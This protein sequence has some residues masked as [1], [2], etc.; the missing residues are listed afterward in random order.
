M[1]FPKSIAI[2]AIHPSTKTLYSFKNSKYDPSAPAHYHVAISV[3]D[4]TFVLL[5]MIT[6]QGEKRKDYYKHN[7]KALQS[8]IDID[9]TDISILTKKSVIDCNQPLYYTREELDLLVDGDIENLEATISEEIITKIKIA[10]QNSPL[11]KPV[12]KK[13]IV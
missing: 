13:V 1:Q 8:V 3:S 9:S 10:I 11:V 5:A 12:V 2:Y 6:S 4:N 7:E